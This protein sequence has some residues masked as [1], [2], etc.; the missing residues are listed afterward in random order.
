MQTASK[1]LRQIH[2]PHLLVHP[3]L[4]RILSPL[5]ARL[6]RMYLEPLKQIPNIIL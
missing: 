4:Q 5:P 6:R 1:V 2:L 3:H